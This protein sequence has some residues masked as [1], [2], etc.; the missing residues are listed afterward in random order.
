MTSEQMVSELNKHGIIAYRVTDNFRD[1]FNEIFK[2][3]D[4]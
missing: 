1:T 4:Q 2:L 3:K